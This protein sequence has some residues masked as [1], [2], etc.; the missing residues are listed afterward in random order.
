MNKLFSTSFLDGLGISV[1]AMCAVHCLVLPLTLLGA[2]WLAGLGIGDEHWHELL[3]LIAI[4]LALISFAIG[5]ARHKDR[6]VLVLGVVGLSMLAGPTLLG[7]H[8]HEQAHHGVE[9]S[10]FIPVIGGLLMAFA[11][12][13]NFRLCRRD[14][15]DHDHGECSQSHD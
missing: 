11:H 7:D 10:M 2:P 4:P 3:L 1:A 5:C 9:F 8:A 12:F 13:R 6:L 15:C 14:E